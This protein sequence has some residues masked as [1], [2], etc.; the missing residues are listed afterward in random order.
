MQTVDSS[1]SLS[2]CLC[3]CLIHQEGKYNPAELVTTQLLTCAANVASIRCVGS[4]G[5][6]SSQTEGP[7]I[8]KTSCAYI[9]SKISGPQSPNGKTRHALPFFSAVRICMAEIR[10]RQSDFVVRVSDH[11]EIARSM[12]S[13]SHMIETATALRSTEPERKDKSC[14]LLILC[15]VY[16]CIAEIQTTALVT[17]PC[18]HMAPHGSATRPLQPS[19]TKRCPTAGESRTQTVSPDIAHTSFAGLHKGVEKRFKS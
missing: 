12:G 3:M 14:S 17:S 5:T 6:R 11:A 15:C 7:R 9:R 19:S 16:V 2:F 1:H 4:S 13:N 18:T 10:L 8:S